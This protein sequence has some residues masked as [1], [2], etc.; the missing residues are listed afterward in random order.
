MSLSQLVHADIVGKPPVYSRIK[1]FLECFDIE[2]P[3]S[4]E[5]GRLIARRIIGAISDDDSFLDEKKCKL[6]LFDTIR[7]G[8]LYF[9][10]E[11][12]KQYGKVHQGRNR[13]MV[14]TDELAAPTAQTFSRIIT[15]DISKGFS[16]EKAKF[17]EEADSCL[18]KY[19]EAYTR[20]FNEL[21]LLEKHTVQYFHHA[22]F[23]HALEYFKEHVKNNVEDLDAEVSAM[24]KEFNSVVRTET[25]ANK[26]EAMLISQF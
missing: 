11:T 3:E 22:L 2:V 6:R 15:N 5:S 8:S 20:M 26:L 10:V 16:S 1:R 24:G 12:N 9:R 21:Q 17:N 13:E 19:V 25:I 4:Q 14:S 7:S 23:D 18:Q